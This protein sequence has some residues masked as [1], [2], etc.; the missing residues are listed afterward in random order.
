[1]ARVTVNGTVSE[2]FAVTTGVKLGGALAP[3]ILSL[4]FSAV[5]TDE[6]REERPRIR[7]AYRMDGRLLNQRLMHFHSCVSTATIHE[8]LFADDCTFKAMTEEEIQ[9]NLDLF[10]TACDNFRL[11]I[12]TL[13]KVVMH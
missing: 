12:N 11:R 13:N 2:A 5:L 9:R 3:A 7:I 1:M 6:Y 4:M 10:A 8:L